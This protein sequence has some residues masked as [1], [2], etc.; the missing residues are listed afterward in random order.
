MAADVA[1]PGFSFSLRPPGKTNFAKLYYHFMQILKSVDFN[2]GDFHKLG[3]AINK[4]V[5]SS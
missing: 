3:L 2:T 5:M 1:N 4:S